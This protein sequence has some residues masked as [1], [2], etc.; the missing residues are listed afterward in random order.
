MPT[1][2]TQL[3]EE[4]ATAAID[5]DGWDPGTIGA[6][7]SKRRQGRFHQAVEAVR[8]DRSRREP[9][10]AERFDNLIWQVGL[11]EDAVHH[12]IANL[13]LLVEHLRKERDHWRTLATQGGR[14]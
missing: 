13:R 12:Q 7:E 8:L 6:E 11:V 5:V 2:R 1:D 3:L 9:T 14:S 10:I 4:L